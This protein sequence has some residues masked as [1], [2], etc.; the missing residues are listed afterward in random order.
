MH[1]T[2]FASLYLHAATQKRIPEG[3]PSNRETFDRS[4]VSSQTGQISPPS[5]T[6]KVGPRLAGPGLG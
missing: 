3:P 6:I 2:N 5:Y 1:F 4:K